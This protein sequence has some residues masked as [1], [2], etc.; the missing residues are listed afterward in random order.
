MRRAASRSTIS[1]DTWHEALP[2]IDFAAHARSLSAGAV[3]VAS[4]A[5]LEAAFK[6]ARAAKRT[7]VIV[8]E[9]DPI[10]LP[11]GRPGGTC[12]PGGV[13][14]LETGSPAATTKRRLKAN[15]LEM[16]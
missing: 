12:R 4:I 9:A 6:A 2:E 10:G 16:K 1:S 3:K 7:Q 5:E 11:T 14:R 15:A 8:I 13:G